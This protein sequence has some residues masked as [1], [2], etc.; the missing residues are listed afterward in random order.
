MVVKARKEAEKSG[1]MLGSGPSLATWSA[2]VDMLA[3]IVDKLAILVE[4]NKA[5]PGKVVPYARPS[6]AFERASRRD[7]QATHE[8]LV[9]AVLPNRAG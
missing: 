5:K 4:A 3:R 1:R 6:T 9:A 8:R 7:M 2:E